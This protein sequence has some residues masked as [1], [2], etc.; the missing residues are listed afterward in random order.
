MLTSDLKQQNDGE[1]SLKGK[2]PGFA[3]YFLCA[4]GQVM[5]LQSI[6]VS[7]FGLVLR[8]KLDDPHKVLKI[9]PDT[10]CSVDVSYY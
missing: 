2:L 8:L 6:L 5:Y 10:K 4:R 7:L 1:L 3:T 9:V